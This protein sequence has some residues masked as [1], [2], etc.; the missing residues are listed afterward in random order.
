MNECN[1]NFNPKKTLKLFG[2]KNNFNFLKNLYKKK[3]FPK[4]LC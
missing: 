3:K 2:F 4:V 1:Q